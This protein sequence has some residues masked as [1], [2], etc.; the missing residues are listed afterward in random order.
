V[1]LF[2][3]AIADAQKKKK[4]KKRITKSYHYTRRKTYGSCQLY[5]GTPAEIQ[6]TLGSE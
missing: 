1:G 3:F 6:P 2:V 5:L 4:K